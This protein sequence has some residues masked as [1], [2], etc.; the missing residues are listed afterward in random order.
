M[1]INSVTLLLLLKLQESCLLPGGTITLCRFIYLDNFDYPELSAV[2]RG[3]RI[4]EGPLY[5][6]VGMVVE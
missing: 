2:T 6:Y 5:M 4:I 1:F 3:V